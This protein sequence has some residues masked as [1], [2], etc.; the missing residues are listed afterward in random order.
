MF[1]LAEDFADLVFDGIR[2]GGLSLEAVQVREELAVDALDQVVAGEGAVVVELAVLVLWRGPRFPAVRRT[3]DMGV[4][5]AFEGGFG[6]LVLFKGVE[7]FQEEQRGGLHGV[8]EL[9]GAPC[10]LPEN[11]VDVFEGLFKHGC[12]LLEA[13][14]QRMARANQ[15]GAV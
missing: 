1:D 11:V 6:G 15:R 2:P 4:F 7:V 13:N 14:Y 10:V 8:I 12:P 9:A 5:P 3:E